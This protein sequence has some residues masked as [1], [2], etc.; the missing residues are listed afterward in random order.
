[1]EPKAKMISLVLI[2]VIVILG[3]L[4]YNFWSENQTLKA[5]NQK[6]RS[7]Q[8][9][10]KQE[11]NTLG[12]RLGEMKRKTDAALAE[13]DNAKKD[14][15]RISFD[16]DKLKSQ[17]DTLTAEKK[18]LTEA[19]SKSQDKKDNAVIVMPSESKEARIQSVKDDS[20]STGRDDVYWERVVKE[21][22]ILKAKA[23]NLEAALKEKDYM[24]KELEKDKRDIKSRLDEMTAAHEEL[25]RELEF[26]KRTIDILS[27]DLVKEKEDK[28]LALKEVRRLRRENSSLNRELRLVTKNKQ[29][30]EDKLKNLEDMKGTLE[31][32]MLE[33]QTML[34]E[35]SLEIGEMQDKLVN[36]LDK[37]RGGPTFESDVVELPP[38]VVKKPA[39]MAQEQMAPTPVAAETVSIPKP[40]AVRS[41]GV[42]RGSII[43]VN[44]KENFVVVDIGESAEIGRASCRERV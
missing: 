36:T 20:G 11:N 39:M 43:A 7:E 35:R 18:K 19:L 32:K 10:L 1:M 9:K 25:I 41:A 24:V 38:V 34:R 30:L 13:L 33:V 15:Q 2:V 23:E 31:S 17:V 12:Q 40:A 5:Q 8:E 42:I 37:T 27:A 14:A 21:K 26:N 16:R 28:R 6:F 44:K 29:L 4:T 22:A 3:I